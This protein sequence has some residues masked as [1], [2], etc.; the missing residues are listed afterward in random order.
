MTA[1]GMKK[2]K[3]NNTDDQGRVIRETVRMREVLFDDDTGDVLR[4]LPC[5]PKGQ[6]RKQ[7]RKARAKPDDRMQLQIRVGCKLIQ[8]IDA[9]VCWLN[10]LKQDQPDPESR[11]SLVTRAIHH[12]LTATKWRAG[13]TTA[14][15]LVGNRTPLLVRLEREM[16]QSID[17]AADCGDV[18]R[19]VWVLDAVLAELALIRK[20]VRTHEASKQEVQDHAWPD[21]AA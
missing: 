10:Y 7:R 1:K 9:G 17:Y 19:T 4:D 12:R 14:D 11:T 18:T 2:M 15:V 13:R 16:M 5:P 20:A 6:Q 21:Q 3:T 8:N